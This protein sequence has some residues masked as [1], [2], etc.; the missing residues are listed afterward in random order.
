M[1]KDSDESQINQLRALYHYGLFGELWEASKEIKSRRVWTAVAE[2]ALEL[3]DLNVAARIYQQILSDASVAITIDRLRNIEDRN[4]LLGHIAVIFKNFDLAQVYF[5]KTID[6][7][8]S[9][10][11]PVIIQKKL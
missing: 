3:L 9:F 1:K 11:Y 6:N 2:T 5:C 4:E 7:S 10:F 8:R